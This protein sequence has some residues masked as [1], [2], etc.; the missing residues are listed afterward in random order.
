MFASSVEFSRTTLHNVGTFAFAVDDGRGLPLL[1]KG[2]VRVDW[3]T[4]LKKLCI[5]M[6][7][8]IVLGCL[9]L[10]T[11][12]LSSDGGRLQDDE[13]QGRICRE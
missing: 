8:S 2:V 4:R 12:D 9:L 1:V 10:L 11:F 5:V 6:S 3:V 13:G 7:R